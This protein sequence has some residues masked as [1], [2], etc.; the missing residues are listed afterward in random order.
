LRVFVPSA[1]GVLTD[2]AGHGEG[3]IAWHL[4]SG[5]ARRGHD[6]VACARLVRLSGR[7]P[8]EI[9]ELGAGSRWESLE[10]LAYARAASRAY[11]RLGGAGRFDVVHWMFPDRPDD[12]VWVPPAGTPFVVGPVAPPWPVRGRRRVRPGDAV[13]AALAPMVR[14]RHARVLASA[15]QILVSSP[16]T[17]N[18]LPRSAAARTRVVAIGVD[19]ARYAVDPPPAEPCVLF[20]G[21]LDRAKG[22]RELVAAVTLLRRD[23]PGARLLIA[24]DGPERDWLRSNTNGRTSLLGPVPHGEIPDLLR[25][26]SVICVPSHGEPYGMV[27]VEAMAA[28]RAVVATAAGGPAFLVNG[29]RGGRLVPPGDI[30]CLA[31]ALRDVLTDRARLTEMGRFNRLRV[32]RDLSLERTIEGLEA[33]Y[34]EAVA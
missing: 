10:R 23:L 31:D 29:E 2:R 21:R 24:G 5:L 16:A 15:A 7:A 6:V 26:A 4:L 27:I 11:E 32:E 3:L 13:A 19:P 22:V 28:G 14:R 17:L 20:V 8:F 33:A 18:A 25:Q 34:E 9:L 30:A 12:V 1:A